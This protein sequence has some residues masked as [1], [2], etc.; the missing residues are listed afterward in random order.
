M[1][2]IEAI[3]KM[4]C[5]REFPDWE[6]YVTDTRQRWQRYENEAKQLIEALHASGFKIVREGAEDENDLRVAA[7]MTLTHWNIDTD[8]QGL[9][10]HGDASRGVKPGALDNLIATVRKFPPTPEQGEYV[11]LKRETL[12]KFARGSGDDWQRAK[13]DVYALL[14]AQR[15]EG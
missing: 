7:L 5:M 12:E 6:T 2:E 8:V 15:E 9:L 11:R 13:M 3:A 14:S 4:L 10:V 1:S